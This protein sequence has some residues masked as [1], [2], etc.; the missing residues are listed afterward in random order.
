M[1]RELESQGVASKTHSPFNSPIWPVRKPDGEWRLTVDYRA[2]NEVTPPLSA[3]VPDMLELQYELESK[4]AKW[5]A[6]IDIANAFFSIPLAAECRPQFAFTWR[7]V[8]YT[9]NRLPQGW[10]H[11]PTICHGL[12]QA[13]LEKGE[14]PEHL[15]YIDDI[16]VWG[17]TAMEVFEKGEKIIHIL[18]KAG[19]AIKKSKVKGPAREIQ[20]LG[21]KWHDGRR[22]IPTEVIN[23]I[24]AMCPPTNKRETQAFLGAIGFWRMHIPE[25]SQIVSPLYLVTRKKINFHWGPEQQQ[26]FAQIKQ[27]I[28]HAVALGPVRTGPEVKNVLYSAAGNNVLSWSLWQKVPGETRGRPLGF[29]SRS[30]R[31]SEAN[32]TPTEKEILAAYEGVQAASEVV[33][34]ETQLLLAPRLPVL[35]WMFKGEVPSTHHATDATWSKWIA[36]ITQRARMGK[37][38]RPGILEIITNW[39]EGENFGLTDEEQEQV[40]RAEEAPP[41]N[42]L[43]AEETHYALFTD[44]SCR[45]VGMNRKWKAAVWSPTRQVAEATEGEGG[46]SQLA[47][48]KAVQLALDIAEREGWPRLYLYTDSWMVANALWGWLRRWKEANWQRGGKAIWA[49][50]EWKDISTRL[51]RLPVKVRH[52]D[53][54][55]PKSRA[56]EEHRNNEQVDRAAKIEVSKIDLDWEHKGELFLARWA[57]DASGHQGRDATYKWARDRGV[58][59]TMDSISQVIHDCETCAAI[60]QAKRVKPLWYGGRWSKYKYG[61]AWQIDYITLPQTRQGKRY[62][63][64]MVEATTGWLETYPVP[65][66]TAQNTIL[67][68][69]KQVLWRHGTPERIESDNGTHFKNSLI[70]TWAR[71]HGI[72]WVYHIPYHAPAAGK[73]ERHNA[74]LKTQLKALGGGSFKNWEQHLA[75]ATWLV[76][77][78][79]STN[80]A[81]PAQ[82]EPLHTID[83]DKVPVVHARGLLGKTVWIKSASSSDKPIRGVVFAQGPGCTWWIMQKD[84]TTRCVPQGDLIVGSKDYLEG[85]EVTRKY[86]KTIGQTLENLRKK[87]YLPQTSPLDA[88]VHNINP[89]DWVLIKAWTNTPLT[90]KFEG[91]YQ[92]LLTTHTAVRTEEKG[93]THITRV[94]G[95]VPPPGE[96][97]SSAPSPDETEWTV[98]P[99]PK[100]L[101]LTFK[102]K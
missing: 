32:Y 7:D 62:V 9:W 92:V 97:P 10:K 73:V 5:Y 94:K 36:L 67:G 8:Q 15:Q 6:T 43:P 42:R 53:A 91:P 31:G 39:P 75:K 54:H 80:R 13:A 38:N 88:N 68:L 1:I 26:A 27:E 40:T 52:V 23:K 49:A 86:L 57:H 28:A 30:Y 84:G 2:L 48:L 100:D 33:G 44:G 64:T 101:K 74:L 19:F 37:L 60:K 11:S 50:K 61:E 96:N 76:N 59:L 81:G 58:D 95:P 102:K 70:N 16:I 35:G 89:G 77:I 21:V 12:I 4:A 45:I 78:R 83:G 29:W 85:E 51:G 56:N 22:Q 79:G 17:N 66:A 46:S 93:W 87:G 20:F 41:Y 71:E 18:L 63:L 99:H 65:H 69:E 55:I 90:P 72:E 14:A 24:T 3:A 98:T 34:T 47:E 25:Y 82:A